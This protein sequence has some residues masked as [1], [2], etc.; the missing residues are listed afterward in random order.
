MDIEI[1]AR[2]IVEFSNK[3][4]LTCYFVGLSKD[5]FV[6]LKVP[7]TAGIRDRLNEGAFLQFR[8]LKDG[9]IISFGAD[10][11]RFQATPVSLA[12]VSYPTEFNEYNLRNEGRVE[13]HLPTEVAVD[14][15]SYPG[16]IVD[17]SPG[18]CKFA[19]S[20]GI[21][22][23]VEDES[24]VAGTFSTMEASKKYA[25][26]GVVTVTEKNGT[27]SS[28]GIKFEGD[29]DLPEGIKDRLKQIEDMKEVEK[30]T[31]GG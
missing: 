16:H 18:G 23:K 31:S 24:S 4:R 15:T 9:K 22:P 11:L 20:G 28:L 8:Y 12:F 30:A 27:G 29:I 26:K 17:I 13:C 19:F 25:F 5:E 14:G 6:L 7:M 21:A 2:V 10:I 1:G 3:E